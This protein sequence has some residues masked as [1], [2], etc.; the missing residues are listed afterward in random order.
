MANVQI[1]FYRCLVLVL[2]IICS[3]SLAKKQICT[4]ILFKNVKEYEMPLVQIE[5]IYKMMSTIH[6]DFPVYKSEESGLYFYYNYDATK[7]IKMFV[8]GQKVGEV[9]GLIASV[10]TTFDPKLWPAGNVNKNDVFGDVINDWMYYFPLGKTFKKVYSLDKIKAVCV[11]DWESI[12]CDSEKL[13]LNDTITSG[14]VVLSDAKIDYF[15]RLPG[16]YTSIRPVY[17]HNR[18]NWYLYYKDNY[19][20]IGNSYRGATN[21]LFRVEDGAVKPEY[22]TGV[23]KVWTGT[24]WTAASGLR[25]LCRGIANGAKSQCQGMS[26]PC[27]NSGTCVY[28]KGNETVCVCRKGSYGAYCE[29]TK[30]CTSPGVPPSSISVVW[31]GRR[32]GEIATSFCATGYRYQPMEFYVCEQGQSWLLESK[33]SCHL[34]EPTKGQPTQAPFTY[35]PRQSPT[36]DTPWDPS[37]DFL[38]F[39]G[40]C[41]AFHMIVPTFIWLGVFIARFVK[42]VRSTQSGSSERLKAIAK[43]SVERY[44]VLFS[45]YSA[46]FNLFFWL[47]FVF[48][49]VCASSDLR[50]NHKN[51]P[52]LLL[53]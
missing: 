29:K 2:G 8:F 5:G 42:A 24:S 53:L 23:W 21:G 14:S 44:W 36:T 50:N 40:P 4:K 33:T 17:K 1:S 26:S 41:L 7:R 20:I 43:I 11:E 6:D 22:V 16:I 37:L 3:L 47:W 32:P 28:T 19:W 52:L 27:K 12:Q 48:V 15:T 10:S 18:Q 35:L 25:I 49:L 34:Q 38:I 46:F 45:I 30:L 31:S 13:Y 39:F 51:T 9:F